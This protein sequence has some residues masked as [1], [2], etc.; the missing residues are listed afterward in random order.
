MRTS[1]NFLK[2]LNKTFLIVLML[3]ASISLQAQN[4]E[5][6][7]MKIVQISPSE[8]FEEALRIEAEVKV[9]QEA[10]GIKTS[11][12]KID[13][14]NIYVRGN[15]K[16]KHVWELGYMLNVKLNIFRTKHNLPRIEEV[17]REPVSRVN[18][19]LPYGMLKRVENEIQILKKFFDITK[20]AAKIEKQRA[21]TAEDVFNKLLQ[22]SKELDYLSQQPTEP[23]SVFAQ[24][25][26]VYQDISSMLN[27]LNITD[28]TVPPQKNE[29][30]KPKDSLAE[31]HKLMKYI[32]KLQRMKDI[33]RT[34]FS[35][36]E[37][38]NITPEETFIFVGMINAEIQILKS[39]LG[40]NH[41]VTPAAKVY[42]EKT[43]SDV[44]QL[45][46][47]TIRRINLIKDLEVQ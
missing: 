18:P 35:G 2:N 11:D 14:S 37:K 39:H 44:E 9:L 28:N 24:V 42:G 15:F 17:G 33:S 46:G 19:N 38:K 5:N 26:R 13:I 12:K 16:S 40:L 21:K 34:D 4:R 41:D 47:W 31:L 7:E 25:M 6:G 30:S 43:P 36:L 8:V 3:F 10:F 1:S 45:I 29:D 20:R 23:S 32:K 27:I 22:I